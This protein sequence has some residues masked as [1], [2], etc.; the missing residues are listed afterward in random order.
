MLMRRHDYAHMSVVNLHRSD[1]SSI[2]ARRFSARC[3]REI[4]ERTI[5]CSDD[6]TRQAIPFKAIGSGNIAPASAP[7]PQRD[8]LAGTTPLSIVADLSKGGVCLISGGATWL[9][10]V[11]TTQTGEITASSQALH[12]GAQGKRIFT[13]GGQPAAPGSRRDD[14]EYGGGCIQTPKTPRT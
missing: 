6:P 14:D 8:T 9:S 12:I 2:L 11:V 5:P 7:K 10:V 13:I 3:Q 1:S 4:R